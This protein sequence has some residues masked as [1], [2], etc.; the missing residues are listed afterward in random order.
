MQTQS[1]SAWCWG[2]AFS[3]TLFA[4]F[5]AWLNTRHYGIG[6]GFLRGFPLVYLAGQDFEPFL[7]FFPLALL[8]DFAI[9]VVLGVLIW[10]FAPRH[11]LNCSLLECGVLGVLSAGFTWANHEVWYGWKPTFW[12]VSILQL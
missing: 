5:Y 10:K 1:R 7:S 3:T 4:A 11:N 8:A 6:W 12:S 9:G 2:P